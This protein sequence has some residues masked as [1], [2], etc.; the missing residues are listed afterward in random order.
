MEINGGIIKRSSA[1]GAPG[2]GAAIGGALGAGAGLLVGNELQN[3]EVSQA[4][5]QTQVSAQQ[6]ELKSQR[7]EIDRLQRNNEVE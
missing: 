3:Q 5:T 7:E 6:R 2:A 4:H 1:V